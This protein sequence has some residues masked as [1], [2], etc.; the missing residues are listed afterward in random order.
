MNHALSLGEP[1]PAEAG[2]F[3]HRTFQPAVTG[4]AVSA[5]QS[6]R[7]TADFEPC[8]AVDNDD[9]SEEEAAPLR[10]VVHG[11]MAILNRDLGWGLQTVL[12]GPAR[13]RR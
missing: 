10:V 12:A 8:P 11:R 4:P 5:R 9:V 13:T 3:P 6:N 1:D 7:K 2:C